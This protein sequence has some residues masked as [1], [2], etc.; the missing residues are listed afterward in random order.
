[1]ERQRAK[2]AEQNEELERLRVESSELTSLKVATCDHS[3]K[4]MIRCSSRHSVW[5]KR[6]RWRD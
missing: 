4:S 5:S 1:M 2:M 3:L 6:K